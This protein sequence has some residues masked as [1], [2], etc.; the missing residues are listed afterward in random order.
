ML[1]R[2]NKA[3]FN[4]SELFPRK[5]IK[6]APT[7]LLHRVREDFRCR[8]RRWQTGWPK[9]SLIVPQ[10]RANLLVHRILCNHEAFEI[11]RIMSLANQR[12]P[13]PSFATSRDALSQ[14]RL[15]S[16]LGSRRVT[17]ENLR[18]PT[19]RVANVARTA[20]GRRA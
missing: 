12:P 15:V 7:V 1:Y 19:Q 11:K 10:F 18:E 16:I 6:F 20:P 17:E 5:R 8:M 4:Q 14:V 3:G 2:P 9:I 13:T